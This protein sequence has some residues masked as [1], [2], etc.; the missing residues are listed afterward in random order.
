M[1]TWALIVG[2]VLLVVLVEAAVLVFCIV[3]YRWERRPGRGVMLGD[4]RRRDQQT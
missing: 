1:S 3:R 2:G 4:S